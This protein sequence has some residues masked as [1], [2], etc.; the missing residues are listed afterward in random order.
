[1]DFSTALNPTLSSRRDIGS[2]P[3]FPLDVL[4]DRICKGMEVAVEYVHFI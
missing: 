3:L 4:D 2:T 1:M